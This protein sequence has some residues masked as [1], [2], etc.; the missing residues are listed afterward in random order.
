MKANWGTISKS[1][2]ELV[3]EEANDFFIVGEL[4][5]SS[6]AYLKVGIPISC[7]KIFSTPEILLIFFSLES[8]KTRLCFEFRQTFCERQSLTVEELK[9]ETEL[10]LFDLMVKLLKVEA[11]FYLI[12]FEVTVLLKITLCTAAKFLSLVTYLKL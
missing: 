3:I 1:F 5:S 4:Q 6:R 8:F 11:L 10:E 2:F 12:L 9:L 7:I